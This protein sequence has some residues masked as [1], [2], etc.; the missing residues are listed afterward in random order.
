MFSC[1]STT[2]LS[3][4]G[5]TGWK[6]DSLNFGSCQTSRGWRRRACMC[7][8]HVDGHSHQRFV[9]YACSETCLHTGIPPQPAAPPGTHQ[10]RLRYPLGKGGED[11]CPA[12][13]EFPHS[14]SMPHSHLPRAVQLPLKKG[15]LLT[16]EVHVEFR[17]PN[18]KLGPHEIPSKARRWVGP[19]QK[20]WAQ[21]AQAPVTE[22]GALIR[23]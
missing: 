15:C 13:A 8:R 22:E 14:E 1:I 7:P 4:S 6:I 5:N 21:Q 11:G 12:T 16:F 19:R 10:R 17:I 20:H 9:L 2:L 18:G 23:N 3:Y